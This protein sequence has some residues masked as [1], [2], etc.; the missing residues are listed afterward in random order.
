M[1]EACVIQMKQ[2]QYRTICNKVALHYNPKHK[3]N[4][5][6]TILIQMYDELTV[7]EETNISCKIIL[8]TLYRYSLIF[9]Y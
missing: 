3:L 1:S 6:V 4:I 9:I 5:Q 2:L 7:E 8:N